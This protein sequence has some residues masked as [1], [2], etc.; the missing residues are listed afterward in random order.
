MQWPSRR[1]LLTLD[2]RSVLVNGRF[3]FQRLFGLVRPKADARESILCSTS[4]QSVYSHLP[5]ALWL[6]SATSNTFSVK[7]LEE[8]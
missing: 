2:V 6:R 7:C 8:P 4:Q 1:K 5:V 3:L